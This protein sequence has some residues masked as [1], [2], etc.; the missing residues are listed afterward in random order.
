MTDIRTAERKNDERLIK[1]SQYASWGQAAK[2][3]DI[4]LKVCIYYCN[5]P[6]PEVSSKIIPWFN[7]AIDTRI[8]EDFKKRYNS[9][10]I[11]R[12]STIEDIDKAIYKKLQEMIRTDIKKSFNGEVFS[13]QYDDIKWRELNR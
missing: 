12:V 4:V 11:S 7:G 5:L 13:V 1:R 2:V 3:I 10:I 6:S 9:P 8:L